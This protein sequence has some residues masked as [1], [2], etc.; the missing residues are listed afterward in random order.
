METG[1]QNCFEN[2]VGDH[3]G[4]RNL[5]QIGHNLRRS[6]GIRR[7][8]K[9]SGGEIRHGW[10]EFLLPIL[11]RIIAPRVTEGTSQLGTIRRL[12]WNRRFNENSPDKS[13]LL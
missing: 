6:S 11:N 8:W 5:P 13:G 10:E 12:N 1:L 9:K 3:V 2:A 7:K 4:A